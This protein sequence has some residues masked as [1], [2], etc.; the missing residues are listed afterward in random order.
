MN[1]TE[2][3]K[4]GFLRQ[5]WSRKAPWYIKV[6]RTSALTMA[7]IVSLPYFFA[8]L[9]GDPIPETQLEPLREFYQSTVDY[10]DIKLHSSIFGDFLLKV[11]DSDA[12]T[13]GSTIIVSRADK[14]K[15]IKQSDF[16]E[17]V[18]AHELGHVRQFAHN[19]INLFQ[20]VY[21]KFNARVK[22]KDSISL[23]EYSLLED[24]DWEDYGIE[25]QA[26][27]LADY[28]NITRGLPPLCLTDGI[29]GEE[30]KALYQ[31]VLAGFLKERDATR[32]AAN[33]KPQV[34]SV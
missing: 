1:R 13:Y 3:L 9:P 33:V 15:M 18:L 24:K 25:Q 29:Y 10:D 23:Y 2:D 11:T 12:S 6:M 17:Y 27:I 22:G 5:L 7:G 28:Y 8:A 26:S 16:Q 31:K 14:Q 20:T 30:R 19:D 4:K 32:P 21:E 34:P